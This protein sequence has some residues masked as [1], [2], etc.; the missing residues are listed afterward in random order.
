MLH[1]ELKSVV[2][3]ENPGR[4]CGVVISW[5]IGV[6]HVPEPSEA[7]D[8]QPLQPPDLHIVPWQ[9]RAHP[10][11]SLVLQGMDQALVHRGDCMALWQ[12]AQ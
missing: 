7:E 1:V 3:V 9:L 8:K 6:R 2:W 10:H 11:P 4:V 12:Q 5:Q